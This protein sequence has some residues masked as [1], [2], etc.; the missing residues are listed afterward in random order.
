MILASTCM[1]PA[2]TLGYILAALVLLFAYLDS[3]IASD[4]LRIETILTSPSS[5]AQHD[6][7]LPPIVRPPLTGAKVRVSGAGGRSPSARCGRCA[8]Y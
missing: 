1:V 5:Y 4:I 2:R 7:D 3:S 8:L 6:V